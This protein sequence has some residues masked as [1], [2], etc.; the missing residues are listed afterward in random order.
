MSLACSPIASPELSYLPC[1]CKLRT[2][3]LPIL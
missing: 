1:F 3:N 2:L